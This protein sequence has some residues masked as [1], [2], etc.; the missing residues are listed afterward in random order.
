MQLLISQISMWTRL[1]CEYAEK[2]DTRSAAFSREML[3][4]YREKL[5][6]L[7]ISSKEYKDKIQES[8]ALQTIATKS[9][10]AMIAASSLRE[11]KFF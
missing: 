1:E 8:E 5:R 7:L 6:V 4:T 9:N 2:G 10:A 3:D 11:L